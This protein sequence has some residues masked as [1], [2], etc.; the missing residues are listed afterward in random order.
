MD[1]S[2]NFMQSATLVL[3]EATKL[4]K[5]KAMPLGLAI[6][7]GVLMLPVLLVSA[8]FAVVLY[9]LG[10]L[11]SVICLP[12][13]KLHELLHNEGQSVK[14]ATQFVVYFLSWSIVFTAYAVLS[15]FLI[16]LTILYSIFSILTYVWSLGGFKFH[17]FAGEEDVSVEVSGKYNVVI[18]IVYIAAMGALL[19]LLPLVKTLPQIAEYAEYTKV[20]FKL[21]LDL[22]KAQ[23]KAAQSWR[24]LFSLVYSAFAFGPN[25]KTIV[26]E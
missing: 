14:H 11:F 18:P 25:P 16:V 24:F 13:K 4:K 17:V 22:F 21:F 6:A 23:I 3:K 12:T 2:V 15:F 10:Y 1:F 20:T 5:Y 8:S 19:I 26:E 9:V 7:T